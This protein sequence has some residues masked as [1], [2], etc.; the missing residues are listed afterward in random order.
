MEIGSTH[1]PSRSACFQ[2]QA[3]GSVLR[4]V[5]SRRPP[6]P[7]P[8]TYTFT[9]LFPQWDFVT[10]IS[11][12][13]C[14][15]TCAAKEKSNYPK[16]SILLLSYLVVVISFYFSGFGTRRRLEPRAAP[17]GSTSSART[18]KWISSQL[19]D[20]RTEYLGGCTSRDIPLG[21]EG[22]LGSPLEGES[23]GGQRY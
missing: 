3:S 20:S 19:Q 7:T 21:A 22:R 10:I 14:S 2:I 12:Y 23:G 5:S 13:F 18:E 17:A 8:D 15:A 11:A 9:L 16:G 4:R 6:E 1:T